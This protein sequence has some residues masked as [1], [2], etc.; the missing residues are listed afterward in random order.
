MAVPTKGHSDIAAV[1]MPCCLGAMARVFAQMRSLRVS[2]YGDRSGAEGQKRAVAKSA[3]TVWI[4]LIAAVQGYRA[5]RA[6]HVPVAVRSLSLAY[7]RG[8]GFAELHALRLL[9]E[10]DCTRLTS[11]TFRSAKAR[12]PSSWK[13][14]A[15]SCSRPCSSFWMRNLWRENRFL[16]FFTLSKGTDEKRLADLSP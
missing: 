11:A 12:I 10:I 5:G 6:G 2:P 8:S 1:I 15:C 3:F 16:L 13:K 4:K 14:I 7:S 9:R